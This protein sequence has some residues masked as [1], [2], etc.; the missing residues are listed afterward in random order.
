MSSCQRGDQNVVLVFQTC[1]MCEQGEPGASVKFWKATAVGK[2]GAG[3]DSLNGAPTWAV[4]ESVKQVLL[5]CRLQD[6][7]NPSN[8]EY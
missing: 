5:L 1:K 2:H 4:H 3:W 8:V 7:R 6:V